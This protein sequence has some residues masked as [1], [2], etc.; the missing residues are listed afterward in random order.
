MSLSTVNSVNQASNSTSPK[1]GRSK[2]TSQDFM[3]LMLLQMKNQNPT[4][5]TDPSSFMRQMISLANYEA[6]AA[7]GQKL[8]NIT[9]SLGTLISGN[10]LGYIGKTIE[11]QGDTTSLQN[12]KA[13]WSYSLKTEAAKVTL[14][15]LDEKGSA[16]FETRGDGK[17]GKHNFA[18]DGKTKDGKQ[19]PDGG[20]Y[21][22]KIEAADNGGK[23]I[24]S[25]TSIFG[26][27]TGT[28]TVDG[29]TLLKIG[30][31]AFQMKSILSV[32]ESK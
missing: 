25:S 3:K 6:Q 2:L 9:S 8:D 28:D 24:E 27:V 32:Q 18:W 16:V 19:L 17:A 23:A 10:G 20:K 7:T 12:G 30:S 13:Q 22:I 11:A 21:T 4:K 26:K 1:I 5:P 31:A 14:K 15:I 29:K